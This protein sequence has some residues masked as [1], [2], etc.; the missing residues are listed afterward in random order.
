MTAALLDQSPELLCAVL[1]CAKKTL[2]QSVESKETKTSAT[3]RRRT[4]RRLASWLSFRGRGEH[5]EKQHKIREVTPLRWHQVR[6]QF[7]QTV[8]KKIVPPF[9][10]FYL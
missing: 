5:L 10:C 2:L 1:T 8:G 7:V 9:F 3:E 4:M 6:G